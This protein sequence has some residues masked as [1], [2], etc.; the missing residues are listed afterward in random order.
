MQINFKKSTVLNLIIAVE[1]IVLILATLFCLIANLDLLVLLKIDKVNP[2]HILAGVGI[3]LSMSALSIATMKLVEKF[4]SQLNMFSN[5]QEL[6]NTV[7]K[8]LF[9]SFNL[10]EIV[11]VSIASGFCEEVFYR[12]VLQSF[13]GIYLASFIFGICHYAGKKYLLYVVWATVAGII[14]GYLLEYTGSLWPP[15]IAHMTNNFVSICFLRY[16]SSRKSSKPSDIE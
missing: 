2:A 13:L 4:P 7:M 3:G 1:T 11:L 14:F 9:A 16:I 12:G 5:Y 15:I 6:V 10:F 8:P